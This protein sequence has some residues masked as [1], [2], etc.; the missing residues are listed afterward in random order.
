[1]SKKIGLLIPQLQDGGVARVLQMLTLGLSDKYEVY[2][3]LLLGDRPINM[4]VKG[5]IIQLC[6]EGNG[7]LGKTITFFKKIRL[8]KKLK[9]RYEFDIVLS[10]GTSANAINILTKTREVVI[11]SEHNVP[12]IEHKIQGK[13]GKVYDKMTYLYRYADLVIAVSKHIR[14]DLVKNYHLDRDKISVIYNGLD[15]DYITMLSER[16]VDTSIMD[17]KINIVDVAALRP[18]KGIWHVI[19]IMPLLI[20]SYPNIQLI[21]IGEGKQKDD[22]I[23]LVNELNIGKYVV[24]LGH[25]SNPF[26][27]VKHSQV[28]VFP[29]VYE[30]FS[31]AFLEAMCLKV[32]VV[33]ADCK[34]GPREVLA[35][36]ADYSHELNDGWNAPYGVLCPNMGLDGLDQGTNLTQNEKIFFETLYKL[37]S[38]KTLMEKYAIKG[39]QRSLDYSNKKMVE[40]Y[41][42][43]FLSV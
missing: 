15:I 12:S 30:G 35:D 20:S 29:S 26:P 39:Y 2:V 14:E 11:V 10:F 31:M 21:I 32:P 23:K 9:K 3:I 25:Q 1:M 18:Q 5:N 6:E 28:F 43:V 16:S 34:S 13:I 17:G 27:Y 36:N 42:R 4:P 22:L 7:V 40:M 33:A 41:E 37:V 8:V 19:K 38:D 24:F